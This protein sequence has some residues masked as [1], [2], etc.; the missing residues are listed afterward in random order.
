MVLISEIHSKVHDNGYWY[1]K[2]R[3]DIVHISK[4]SST[5]YTEPIYNKNGNSKYFNHTVFW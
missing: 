1:I 3:K 4:A 5:Y 2:M